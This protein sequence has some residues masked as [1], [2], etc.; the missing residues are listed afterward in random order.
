[1]DAVLFDLGRVLVEWDPFLPFAGRYPRA[2]VERFFADV[3]FASFNHRQDAGRSWADARAELLASHPHHVPLLDVYVRR[4]AES[5]PH[6]V[7][8]ASALVA[9][10][11][12]AGLRAHGL[13]N[14]S[15]ETYSVAPRQAPVIARLEGVLVSGEVGL[16]K[17]DARIFELAAARFG[18]DPRRTLF[19]DDAARNVEGARATGYR[20]HLFTGHADLRRHLV[21]LGVPVP[22][23]EA[24][25][26][27]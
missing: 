16:A 19:V 12:A 22:G 8:G 18:L 25:P 11:L 10:V 27:P 9:D 14:W 5:V 7:P 21:D 1:M 20:A 13:T 2:D 4:F 23:Q 17:P 3:D 15:A 6:E 26:P 24:A